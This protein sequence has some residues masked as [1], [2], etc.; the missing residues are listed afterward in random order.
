MRLRNIPWR[1]L[2]PGLIFPMSIV[3]WVEYCQ[4]VRASDD[5][6]AP[7]SWYGGLLNACLNF[8]ALVYSS[9]AQAFYRLGISVGKLWIEPRILT[10]FLL[11][12]VFWYWVGSKLQSGVRQG[13]THTVSEKRSRVVLVLH[14]LGAA[15]WILVAVGT[16]YE[17]AFV[18]HASSRYGLRYLYHLYRDSEL[19]S[20]AQFLW[21]VILAVYYSRKFVEGFRGRVMGR[22]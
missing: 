20:L 19:M 1:F 18:V 3:T 21:S 10:F 17:L 12:C 14:A 7:W 6:P 11:V 22:P 5:S 13:T 9:P 8:P 16:A 15:L 2:L 4:S